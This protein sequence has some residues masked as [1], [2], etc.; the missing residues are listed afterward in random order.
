MKGDRKIKVIPKLNQTDISNT[1]CGGKIKTR[2][3]WTFRRNVFVKAIL[4]LKKIKINALH[5]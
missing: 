5:V 4:N 1:I 3:L 2:S